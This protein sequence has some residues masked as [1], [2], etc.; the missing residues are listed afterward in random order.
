MR[1]TP[2]PGAPVSWRRRGA[3]AVTSL[4]LV[5]TA[6]VTV[7]PQADAAGAVSWAAPTAISGAADVSTSGSLVRAAS[8]TANGGTY[9]VDA[10]VNGVT[11][12]HSPYT[13]STTT[14][15][16]GDILTMSDS[17]RIGSYEGFG[18]STSPF[19][20]L[21]A[22][23][24]TLLRSGDYN[25]G[26]TAGAGTTARETLTLRNLTPGAQYLFQVWVND[27]RVKNLGQDNPGLVT[28]VSDGAGSTTLE[29]NVNNALGGVG[30]YV[31]GSFTAD[32]A[33]KA[34][35]FTGGNTGVDTSSPS[36]TA[37]VNAYQL[38]RLDGGST[39]PVIT[40]QPVSQSVQAGG[41]ATFSVTAD[42]TAPLSYQWRRNGQDVSGATGS[43]LTVSGVQTADAGT[44][45]VTVTNAAGSVTSGPATLTVGATAQTRPRVIVLTDGEV[46]DRSSMIRFLHYTSDFDVAGIVQVNSRYQKSG[47]SGEK[48][49][50]AELANYAKV[51]PNLRVHNPNFPDAAYLQGVSRV[52]NENPNDLTTAPPDMQTKDTPGEQLIIN[53]LLDNDPRPVHIAVWGGANT[54]A[55]A[56]W[57]L[58][59]SYSSADFARAAAKARIYCI[60]YQ[61]GGGQWIED[62]IHEARINEAYRWDNVWDY[63]SLTGP[64]PDYVKAYMTSS[65]LDANVK[66]GHGPLGAMYPQSFVSEGD[67][68]SFLHE[69]ANGLHADDDFTLGGWG[70]RSAYDDPAK[71]NHLT[72]TGISDDG[73]SNKMYWRWIPAAQ[74]D[75]AARMRWD[76]ASSY[77]AA[78]HQPIAAVTGSLRQNV[79]PGQLISLDGSP[80]SD[81]DRNALSYQWWQYS[82]ADSVA[83]KVS[84]SNAGS[85]KGAGFVVPNEPGKQIQIILEVTDNGTPALTSYARIIYTIV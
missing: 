16:N 70:G 68:P 1:P 5:C 83:A 48:W 32:A 37:I 57:R 53:T 76:T 31:S 8:L 17:S 73:D 19:S 45:T 62:N 35:T 40:R 82:D 33:S 42:G 14:F 77:G 27:Y 22:G 71:P 23:Y 30:Q 63:Q 24:Q 25:D 9:D 81:P 29:H 58:K 47:H 64:S 12:R 50:E 55:S 52:G 28:V 51:L 78:N 20:T 72:D 34:F 80:S 11:F 26:D 36:A 39:A 67:T 7:A 75:F 46:D 49:L 60:W 74:N 65:W 66:T 38:R 84:I 13:G 3:V 56:L 43:S 10:T 79:S 54:M 21:P 6:A 15:P 2:R 41:T 61:D 4:A 85:Q 44:Y 18:G 59:T 69:I